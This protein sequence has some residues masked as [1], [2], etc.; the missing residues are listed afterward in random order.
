MQANLDSRNIIDHF[1]TEKQCTTIDKEYT[2]EIRRYFST[3]SSEEF[4]TFATNQ[5]YI[6]VGYVLAACAVL[7]YGVCPI[8]K[9][10]AGVIHQVLQS[11]N[12]LSPVIMLC[13]GVPVNCTCTATGICTCGQCTCATPKFRLSLGEL[14]IR[15][16]Y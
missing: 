15:H 4:K 3:L 2:K 16:G 14:C 11:S 12:S 8:D 13:I 9:F 1:I 7:K 6:N 5:I 10:N